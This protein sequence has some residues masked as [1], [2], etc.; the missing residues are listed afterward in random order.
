MVLLRL[1]LRR[2]KPAEAV[3]FQVVAQTPNIAARR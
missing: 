3:G 1:V 2:F